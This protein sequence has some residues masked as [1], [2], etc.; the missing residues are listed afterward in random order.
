MEEVDFSEFEFPL[1][2]KICLNSAFKI[3]E[4]ISAACHLYC[5]ICG[6]IKPEA[7]HEAWPN[8]KSL[9]ISKCFK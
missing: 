3:D 7:P 8:M 2:F 1:L 4:M 9:L 6:A 5:T